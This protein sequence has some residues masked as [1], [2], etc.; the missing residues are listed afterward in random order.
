VRPVELCS[1]TTH[2]HEGDFTVSDT[3]Q[4]SRDFR[5]DELGAAIPDMVLRR[6]TRHRLMDAIEAADIVY[7]VNQD[8]EISSE[9]DNGR[10]WFDING[11]EGRML[12]VTGRWDGRLPDYRRE[13]LLEVCDAW[14]GSRYLPAAHLVV[15]DEGDE[16]VF[17]DHSVDY[18]FGVT[19]E[20]IYQHIITAVAGSDRLF[21]QLSEKFPEGLER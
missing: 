2:R 17:A 6:L 16:C 3:D 4:D 9:W 19:D 10:I 11:R 7:T 8:R 21:D 14:N 15:D 13:E 5:T 18:A 1:A 12:T 20:Q